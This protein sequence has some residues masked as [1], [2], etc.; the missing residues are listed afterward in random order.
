MLLSHGVHGRPMPVRPG[1]LTRRQ[2]QTVKMPATHHGAPEA[3]SVPTAVKGC[4][5]KLRRWW[6]HSFLSDAF[7]VAYGT[8]GSNRTGL[9]MTQARSGRQ[10]VKTALQ[11]FQTRDERSQGPQQ[12]R[13][14][15]GSE[16]GRSCGSRTSPQHRLCVVAVESHLLGR[17]AC[18]LRG[19][20][21]PHA[22]VAGRD[23]SRIG[24]L[25]QFLLAAR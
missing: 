12:R 4:A 17:E 19:A 15:G 9:M 18:R 13:Q 22:G 2:R 10:R 20:I 3:I 1:S 8:N 16:R 11:T 23:R 24:H 7:R 14:R 5:K 21:G 25:V 6:P